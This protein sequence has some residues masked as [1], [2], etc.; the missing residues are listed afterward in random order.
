MHW[1]PEFSF[2][3]YDSRL[4]VTVSFRLL[5]DGALSGTVGYDAVIYETFCASD[6]LN[7]TIIEYFFSLE[8]V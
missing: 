2:F 6:P 8:A 1:A 4:H 3:I 5:T 7:L